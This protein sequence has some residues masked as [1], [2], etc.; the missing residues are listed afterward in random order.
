VINTMDAGYAT[1]YLADV[2]ATH[3]GQGEELLTPDFFRANMPEAWR[4]EWQRNYR[5]A[6]DVIER[7]AAIEERRWPGVPAS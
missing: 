3:R 5:A 4:E 7:H 1:H 6:Q 2:A